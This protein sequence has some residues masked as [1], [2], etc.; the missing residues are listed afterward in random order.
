MA[1]PVLNRRLAWLNLGERHETS[2]MPNRVQRPN[3]G[4][5]CC[6]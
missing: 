1:V 3:L 2:G 6:V 4:L 5:Q